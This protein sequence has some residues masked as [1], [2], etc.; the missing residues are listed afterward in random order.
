MLCHWRFPSTIELKE[1]H[2]FYSRPSSDLVAC[3]I[4]YLYIW[5]LVV[6][7]RS[8]VFSVHQSN[9]VKDV[10]ICQDVCM[11]EYKVRY[12][13]NSEDPPDVG[14]SSEDQAMGM[15]EI[16]GVAQR[17]AL[18]RLSPAQP[19]PTPSTSKSSGSTDPGVSEGYVKLAGD[20]VVI[21]K[22]VLRGIK[23]GAELALKG[24]APTSFLLGQATAGDLPFEVPVPAPHQ[25]HC[26]ICRKDLPTPKALRH[27]LWAHKGMIHYLCPK[28]GK[29]LTSGRTWDM[30]K[31]SCGSTEFAHNCRECRKGYHQKQSLVQ[32][33]KAKH[34]P[35]HV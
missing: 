8:L 25:V 30:H 3:I 5:S 14:L 35:S 17:V 27:H 13:N 23:R 34:Q 18:P 20:G 26:D 28:C 9:L 6:F 19:T 7:L 22:A 16:L 33:I 2:V 29:H 21:K 4:L 10:T 12:P 24:Q 1:I 32:H 31:E 15:K 11:L